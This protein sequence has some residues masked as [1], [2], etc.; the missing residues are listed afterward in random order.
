MAYK[1]RLLTILTSPGMIL[2]VST[3]AAGHSMYDDRFGVQLLQSRWDVSG[4]YSKRVVNELYTEYNPF[5]N[6]L[7][8]SWDI[9]VV[10]TP[11]VKA[12]CKVSV[13][14]VAHGVNDSSSEIL[15]RSSDDTRCGA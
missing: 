13:S 7:R 9:Q 10:P 14:S 5:T 1:W 8:T 6:H 2:Q 11:S 15:W 3:R 12:T 4:T